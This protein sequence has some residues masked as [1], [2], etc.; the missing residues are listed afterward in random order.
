MECFSAAFS[1]WQQ[2]FSRS[3]AERLVSDPTRARIVLDALIVGGYVHEDGWG[4]LRVL[5]SFVRASGTLIDRA[6]DRSLDW[7]T[8]T[9]EQV[10]LAVDIGCTPHLE[11]ESRLI[12][13]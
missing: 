4:R 1:G 13:R 2:P 11:A 10:R 6:P 5:R 7:A 8:P 12:V 3:R 9:G